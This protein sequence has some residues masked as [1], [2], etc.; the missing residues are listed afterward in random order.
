M[1]VKHK[2]PNW[3][4]ANEAIVGK[5][6]A[7][8]FIVIVIAAVA[9]DWKLLVSTFSSVGPLTLTLNLAT[10]LLGYGISRLASL[11]RKQAITI[12][13]ECGLQNGTLGIFIALT[14]LNNERMMV[15]CGVY[16]LLMMITGGL[17]IGLFKMT[18]P[19]IA[20]A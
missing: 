13:F 20:I 5:I 1:L 8:L 6:A 10:M 19:K 3:A 14:L 17:L 11:D 7:I 15:P 18:E 2:C 4:L 12:T 9:K 16:S